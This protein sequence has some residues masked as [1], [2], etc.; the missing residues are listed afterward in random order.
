[1]LKLVPKGLREDNYRDWIYIKMLND[2]Q[3]ELLTETYEELNVTYPERLKLALN[4]SGNRIEQLVSKTQVLKT[5]FRT[6]KKGRTRYLVG[7]SEGRK[8]VYFISPTQTKPKQSN[9]VIVEKAT[10]S[11]PKELHQI[12]KDN[13]A[14]RWHYSKTAVERTQEKAIK[15]AD[16]AVT[17]W[18]D[19]V[20][21]RKETKDNKGLRTPQVGALHA[22]LAHETVFETS[23]ATVVMPTGTGK[24]ETMVSLVHEKRY[25]KT[26]VIVPTNALRDQIARTFMTQGILRD[27]EVLKESADFPVVSKLKHSLKSVEDVENI[28][29]ASNIVVATMSSISP[30]DDQVRK[31]IADYIDVLIIDEAHHIPAASWSAFRALFGETPIYQFTATPFR[32]DG[33]YVQGKIIYAYPLGKAQRENYFTSIELAQVYSYFNEDE[34]IASKAIDLLEKDL[35]DGKDHMLMARV[36]SIDRAKDVFK[37]YEQKAAKHRPIMV[38]SELTVSERNE[39]LRKLLS[40]ESR[41]VVCVDMLGEGFDLKQLKI[42]AMHDIH[43]SLAITL[44]FIG[45]FT[46]TSSDDSLG[47]AKVIVNIANPKV[48]KKLK[49][50]YSEDADWDQLVKKYSQTATE[51]E[52]EKSDFLHSF[53]STPQEI[54]AQNIEPRMSTVVYKVNCDD[55]SPENINDLY[56]EEELFT[57][58]I[59]VNN[60]DL[61]CWFVTANQE[62]L[63]WANLKDLKNTEYNLYVLHWDKKRKLLFINSSNNTSTHEELAKK[64]CGNDIEIIKGANVYRSMYGVKRLVPINLGLTDVTSRTTRFTMFSGSDVGAG[65]DESQKVNK[66]KTNMFGLGYENGEKASIGCSLKGRIWSYLA[67]SNMKDWT[68]WCGA[69]GDKLL[70]DRIDLDKIYGSFVTPQELTGKRPNFVPLAVEWHLGF[71][72]DADRFYFGSGSTKTNLIST[73]LELSNHSKTDPIKF[74]VKTEQ[75]EYE[76]E[77]IFTNNKRTAY[78]A[79]GVDVDLTRGSTTKPLSQWLDDKPLKII[80]EG[81]RIIEED[82]LFEYNSEI[83]PFDSNNIEVWD[84]SKTDL[85][86]E[87]QRLEKRPDSIQRKVIEELLNEGSWEIV[88]DDD[89]S[90]EAADVVAIK[91]VDETLIVNLYHC[92]FSS[93]KTAGARVEDLYAVCGQAQKSALWRDE[94]EAFIEHLLER[95]KIRL[96]KGLVSRFEK[97]DFQDLSRIAFKLEYLHKDFN[98]LVVQPGLSKAGATPQIL[99]L[100]GATSLFLSNTINKE[101]KI[102]ASR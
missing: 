71:I 94:P 42:A 15:S 69:I 52:Q 5:S 41:V 67:A 28:F 60:K 96:E 54:S 89:G 20:L 68:K 81:D 32:N 70:N 37:I 39:S 45:R 87:S 77:I 86:K 2:K 91:V 57:R 3:S 61:V 6:E 9:I 78:R 100:L 76:Y 8:D 73:S 55:W 14:I 85:K 48:G 10:S 25:R 101:L 72:L 18:T 82:F 51:A 93:A 43:K 38:H 27:I 99:K 30:S 90:G 49:E 80:F 58:E 53:V 29:D 19:A 98:I 102:I 17:S 35:L 46:R 92:K 12:I 75:S 33:R 95:A 56:K 7:D 24:T 65:L 13:G 34:E 26:L 74:K 31:K 22:I 36:K 79:I 47:T 50:L 4:L 62:T 88:F 21:I 66:T 40:K 63:K 64:V 83:S 11:V 16:K 59:A 97:G 44:Q 1:M 84:W 23:P